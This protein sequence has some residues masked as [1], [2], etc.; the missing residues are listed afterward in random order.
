MSMSMRLG[1]EFVRHASSLSGLRRSSVVAT[2]VAV[3]AIATVVAASP[4]FLPTDLGTLGGNT[5]YPLALNDNGVAVG[6]STLSD[7]T[8]S[9]AFRWTR[10]EG[11]IDLGTLGGTLSI[12]TAVNDG[13][14]IA[15]ASG[16]AT[17]SQHAFIWTEKSGM[18]DLGTLPSLS[19]SHATGISSKN[20][21]IGLSWK[22]TNDFTT[23]GF[24]WTRNAGMV[25][26]GGLGGDTYPNA[27]NCNGLVVGTAYTADF[28]QSRPFVWTQSTGLIDLGS[29][30]GPY[31]EALAV[32][33]SG[34]VVGYS[35]TAG[36][37]SYPHP[38]VWTYDTGM[39]DLGTLANGLSGYAT[40]VN[41]DGIVVGYTSTIDNEE[42]RAF[43]WS[44]AT[45][46]INLGT[47]TSGD[48]YAAG[49][50]QDG[51]IVGNSVTA[52]GQGLQGFAWTPADGLINIDLSGLG[53]YTQ[54][55]SISD[56]GRVFGFKYRLTGEG[57][58]TVW[59]A[60]A[61]RGPKTAQATSKNSNG[62]G[63]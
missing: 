43:K 58:A 12:A 53:T 40:A 31:G 42:L 55:E 11:M 63:H 22:A 15:G 1:S 48:S 10:G 14:V 20:V 60:N 24:V 16:T 59:N 18:V 23:H 46:M 9:H 61:G 6:Y 8:L 30:G 32:S 34:V 38:F 44:Y 29:L 62:P 7:P 49:I 50:S 2:A 45:G 47:T 21:V 35:Y 57:R 27:V 26:L 25:D 39:I 54:I 36:D 41:N 51:V 5:S 3:G 56:G 37:P 17:G 13:G 52:D 4:T 33:D 28:A 19:N